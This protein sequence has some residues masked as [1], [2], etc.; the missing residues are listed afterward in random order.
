MDHPMTVGAEQGKVGQP[1]LGLSADVKRDTM[2]ALDV[3][4][5]VRP[6]LDPEVKGAHFAGNGKAAPLG[7]SDL[8]AT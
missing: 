1:G 2:V 7:I 4:E 8:L 3:V 5:S 6:V